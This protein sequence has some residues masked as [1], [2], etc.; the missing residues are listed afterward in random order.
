[1]SSYSVWASVLSTSCTL[2]HLI[3]TTASWGGTIIAPILWM[4]EPRLRGNND[5]P[6]VTQLTSGDSLIED[7][8][9]TTCGQE[10]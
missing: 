10:H 8:E 5:Q 7:R 6:K 1:M 3:P 2:P 4:R 9:E